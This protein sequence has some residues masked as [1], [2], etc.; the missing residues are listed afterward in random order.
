MNHYIIAVRPHHNDYRPSLY[1]K[2]NGEITDYDTV[3]EAES[4]ES[5]ATAEMTRENM[6]QKFREHKFE[7]VKL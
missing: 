1:Y 3:G 2:G 4:F 5:L 7:I 6:A